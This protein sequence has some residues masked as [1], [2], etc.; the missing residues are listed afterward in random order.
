MQVRDQQLGSKAKSNPWGTAGANAHRPASSHLQFLNSVTA[1]F[2][3]REPQHCDFDLDLDALRLK[4]DA[5]AR[6]EPTRPRRRSAQYILV[7]GL[8]RPDSLPS[9]DVG[10]RRAVGEYFA[11]GRQLSPERLERALLPFTPSEDLRHSVLGG[12]AAQPRG[13]GPRQGKHNAPPKD[14]HLSDIPSSARVA[15]NGLR[16]SARNNTLFNSGT[17]YVNKKRMESRPM[18]ASAVNKRQAR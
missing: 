15:Y 2:S 4:C 16:M 3:R 9:D 13:S 12:G 17:S 8:E 1:D 10:L 5:E 18:D 14:R 6:A 11:R 7:R